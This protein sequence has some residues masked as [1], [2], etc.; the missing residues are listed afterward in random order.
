MNAAVEAAVDPTTW[1]TA[2]DWVAAVGTV[3]ALLFAL[4][5]L[6]LELRARHDAERD[7]RTQA[8]R[9]RMS[10]ARRVVPEVWMAW[11]PTV[12]D[13]DTGRVSGPPWKETRNV[14]ISN[15][16]DLPIKMVRARTVVDG[17]ELFQNVVMILEPGQAREV[18]TDPTLVDD[19]VPKQVEME[20]RECYFVDAAGVAW[21]LA[22][23]G[24]LEEI[25]Q[26]PT[27]GTVWPLR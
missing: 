12:T 15:H 26:V 22:E 1:G 13:P 25:D 24:G 8:R 10:Q 20:A 17:V 23:P 6:H 5:A 18:S 2:A 27:D 11:E 19:A 7:R 14:R 4:A 9:E 21:R 16:S 3:A